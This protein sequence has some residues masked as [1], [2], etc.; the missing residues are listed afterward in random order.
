MKIYF[1]KEDIVMTNRHMKRCSISPIIR[2]KQI[3][4]TMRYYLTS[5]RMTLLKI[6][7]KSENVEKG[8]PHA[9]LT[10]M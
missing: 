8:N 4:T 6:T 10:R 3:K 7:I 1:S 2:G 9:L 5:V